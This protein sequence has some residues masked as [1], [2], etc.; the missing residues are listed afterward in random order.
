[1]AR[2]GS[3]SVTLR[4]KDQGGG[5]RIYAR[6]RYDG[7]Y[8]ERP[9]GA[10]WLVPAGE[11]GA[12]PN[13]KV[14]GDWRERRGRATEGYFTVDSAREQVPKIVAAYEAE[15][16]GAA[17]AARRARDEEIS[18]LAAVEAWLDWRSADDPEGEHEAW[19]HAHAKNTKNTGLRLAREI[20]D[21]R[22]VAS[23]TDAELRRLLTDGL[24]P[25]RNG[26]VIEG[27]ETSRKM[28]ATY[29]AALRGIFSY[30]L[31]RGWI[32]EDPAATLP[33]YRARKK[34]AG[35]PLRR[36]EYLT[37]DELH[38]VLSELRAGEEGKR[39]SQDTRDQDAAMAMVMG[40]AGLRPGE[41]IALLWEDVDFQRSLL[42]VVWSRT[43]GVTDTPKSHAG[44]VVPLAPEVS[45]A[46]TA[47]RKRDNLIRAR[48]RVFTGR[49]GGHIDL[50]S[51][52]DRFGTAQDRADVAPR[53]DV[54]QLRNTFGTVTASA[55]VPLRTIQEWMGHES[56]ST[57][58]IYASFMPR[59][60]D[61]ALVSQ[62]FGRTSI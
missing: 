58:E 45:E 37:P 31:K 55:G 49:D 1:M 39:R 23:V 59:H 5:P 50:S 54:R 57:T 38:A 24:K 8:V 22:A 33:A 6:W 11:T 9:I 18:V 56:I 14:I 32:E 35:D 17:R 28:R 21:Q 62:A 53:R 40:M 26:A 51:F 4:V 34:R 25:M 44:R 27:R 29:A 60:E 15:K 2:T 36:E 43:M 7:A 3:P 48:D 19:K 10:G 12:K 52:R 13:G 47:L 20:G 30:A 41:A 16:A 46:L 61:A 42:R